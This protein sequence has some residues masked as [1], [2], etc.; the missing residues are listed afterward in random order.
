[1]SDLQ[2]I[3]IFGN[4][5]PEKRLQGC[6]ATQPDVTGKNTAECKKKEK[7]GPE[8]EREKTKN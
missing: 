4:V 2:P 7:K 5:R 6:F 8:K 3:S 1:L